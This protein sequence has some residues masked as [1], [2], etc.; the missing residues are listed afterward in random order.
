MCCEMT[1]GMEAESWVAAGS[2]K[3][4]Q[5]VPHRR[6][7]LIMLALT[8]AYMAYGFRTKVMSTRVLKLDTLLRRLQGIRSSGPC[9]HVVTVGKFECAN[10]EQGDLGDSYS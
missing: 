2:L 4:P 9:I 7:Y 5:S 1:E 8:V 10:C 6:R 3:R